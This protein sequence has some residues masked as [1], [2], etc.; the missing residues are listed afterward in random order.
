M[1]CGSYSDGQSLR[2]TIVSNTEKAER[3]FNSVRISRD[4]LFSVLRLEHSRT[5]T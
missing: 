2:T 4:C 5:N 1:V 3:T